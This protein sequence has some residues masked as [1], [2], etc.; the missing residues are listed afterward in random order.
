MVVVF[1]GGDVLDCWQETGGI[2]AIGTILVMF[3]S[4]NA[5]IQV[6]ACRL[7]TGSQ[8][9]PRYIHFSGKTCACFMFNH[10]DRPSFQTIF[11]LETL[12]QGC[13][14]TA[15]RMF[16]TR[17]RPNRR[18]AGLPCHVRSPAACCNS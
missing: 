10:V 5:C 14:A 4:L 15:A 9:L 6:N 16:I 7:S 1:Q 3:F 2:D 13:L 12:F 18:V 8:L 17:A 11:P